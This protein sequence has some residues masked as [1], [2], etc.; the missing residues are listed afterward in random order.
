ME[1]FVRVMLQ[2]KCSSIISEGPLKRLQVSG[3]KISVHRLFAERL[4]QIIT[5]VLCDKK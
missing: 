4:E 5:I 3:S 1:E 2:I